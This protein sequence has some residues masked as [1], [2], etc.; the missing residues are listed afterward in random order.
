MKEWDKWETSVP[1]EQEGNEGEEEGNEEA[2]EEDKK[3]T[4]TSRPTLHI[5]ST[6]TYC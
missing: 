5:T 6:H 4:K 2:G 3:N 1:E